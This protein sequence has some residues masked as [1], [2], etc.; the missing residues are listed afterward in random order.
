MKKKEAILRKESLSL[1]PKTIRKFPFGDVRG[2][3]E[4][5]QGRGASKEAPSAPARAARA[6][7]HGTAT[8]GESR[9]H[10]LTVLDC[11][12]PT[13]AALEFDSLH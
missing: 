9:G 1:S 3:G 10:F 13:R 5:R 4:A 12:G 6:P 11:H 7:L 8:P 2:T